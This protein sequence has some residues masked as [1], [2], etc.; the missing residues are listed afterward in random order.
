MLENP[1]VVKTYLCTRETCVS[2]C[3]CV[4][5]FNQVLLAIMLMVSIMSMLGFNVYTK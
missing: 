5:V 1:I 2:G 3:V 4:C